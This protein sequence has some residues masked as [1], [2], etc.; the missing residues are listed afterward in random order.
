M[1]LVAKTIKLSQVN[2]CSSEGLSNSRKN[3]FI[4]IFTPLSIFSL[5]YIFHDGINWTDLP[6][7]WRICAYTLKGIDIYSL[8][9]SSDFLPEIGYIYIYICGFSC[10]AIGLSASEYILRGLSAI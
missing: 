8:R 5:L 9:G 3:F 7:Q 6:T 4:L 10:F 1:N 2:L